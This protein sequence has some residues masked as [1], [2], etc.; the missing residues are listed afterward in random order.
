MSIKITILCQKNQLNW[1]I[2][3]ERKFYNKLNLDSLTC[4]ILNF[5]ISLILNKKDVIRK[6]SQ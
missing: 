1:L 4:S 3:R 2:A 5:I 6:K